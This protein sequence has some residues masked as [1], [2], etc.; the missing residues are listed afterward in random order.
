MLKMQK[1]AND[2]AQIHNRVFGRCLG[3]HSPKLDQNKDRSCPETQGERT[4]N[5]LKS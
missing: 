1:D 5:K 4:M 2:V 3:A